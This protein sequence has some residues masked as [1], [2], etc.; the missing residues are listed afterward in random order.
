VE[1][2]LRRSDAAVLAVVSDRGAG[3]SPA[4]Q[5]RIFDR[6]FTTRGDQGG[7]GLGLAMVAAV[8]KSHGA[9]IAVSSEPGKG[10]RFEVRFPRVG[11]AT[12]RP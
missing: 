12:G 1:V 8:V 5:D 7:T 11:P 3:I 10:S 4:N 2:E 9:E 6:F